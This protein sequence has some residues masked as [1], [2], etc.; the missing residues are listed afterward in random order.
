[1]I[2]CHNLGE[3]GGDGLYLLQKGLFS[4]VKETHV[5]LERTKSVIK[6]RPSKTLFPV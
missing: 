3:S 5:S 4:R 6:E 1:M 2:Y